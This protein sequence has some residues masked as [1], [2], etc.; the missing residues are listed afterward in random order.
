MSECVMNNLMQSDAIE[1]EREI[2]IMYDDSTCPSLV[3][4]GWC[5]HRS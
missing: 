3:V 1:G 2:M 4:P 5:M